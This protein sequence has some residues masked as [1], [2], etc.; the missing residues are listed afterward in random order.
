VQGSLGA[1]FHPHLQL[2]NAELILRKG[3]RST[4]DSYSAFNENDRITRTGLTGYLRERGLG[5]IFLTGLAYDFC[6]RHSAIDGM[7]AGFETYVVEDACRAIG[8]GDSV[9][10]TNHAFN[11]AGVR[12][13][14]SAML[15]TA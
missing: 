3:S 1:A 5:R 13:I 10:A 7:R 6:V 14:T 9:A 4:I 11:D 12:R 15:D 2:D 8:L